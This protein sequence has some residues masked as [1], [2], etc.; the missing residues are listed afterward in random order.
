MKIQIIAT[1]LILIFAVSAYA[2]QKPLPEGKGVFE[3]SGHPALKGES[4]RVFYHRPT[5]DVTNLPVLFVMHGVNRNAD[6]YRNNWVELSEKHKI[7]VIV[8]EFSKEQFPGSRMYNYGNLRTKDGTMNPEEEWSYSLIDPI[9]EHVKK[10]TG[11]RAKQYDLFG[12]SAGSQFA[13]RFFLFKQNTKVNR[14][15]A[16]NAG[17]YTML[18][19]DIDFP[20]G[21]KEM[22]YHERKLKNALERKLIVQLGE[23][24]TDPNHRNLN[25]SPEAMKQGKHRLE[26]G[27][28]FYAKAKELAN[29]LNADFKWTIRKVPRA[30]HNNAKMAQDIAGHLYEGK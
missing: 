6:T 13:H 25:V 4:M 30:E 5:G 19:L 7:L 3:F 8:P 15:V 21:L 27:E 1:G 22:N 26:R 29:T 20:F 28:N 16:A 10:T 14:V 12:H 2:V 24:D 18:D 23:E 11:N 9:F 17:T